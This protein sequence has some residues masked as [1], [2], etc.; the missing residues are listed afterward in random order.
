MAVASAVAA[1]LTS[2]LGSVVEGVVMVTDLNGFCICAISAVV[3]VLALQGK[4]M[5]LDM[6]DVPRTA[7]LWG[8]AMSAGIS[9]AAFASVAAVVSVA[10]S[11]VAV[12]VVVIVLS[13]SAVVLSNAVLPGIAAVAV[14][15]MVVPK[16][17]TAAPGTLA[18]GGNRHLSA[19]G[20]LHLGKLLDLTTAMG[21]KVIVGSRQEVRPEA[22]LGIRSGLWSVA[23]SGAEPRFELQVGSGMS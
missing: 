16:V 23:K 3:Q 10:A 13:A 8:V 9:V 19:S 7:G 21:L 12:M 6:V 11:P 4:V 15:S 20:I 1:A 14:R 22:G 17:R 18:A 5:L 2:A